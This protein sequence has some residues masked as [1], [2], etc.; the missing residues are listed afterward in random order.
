MITGATGLIG[1]ALVAHFSNQHQLTLVGRTREK[2]QSQFPDRYSIVTW[3]ELKTRGESII[4]DQDVIINLAGENIG[5][6]RWSKK[7]KQK[8]L[9]SRVNATK[10]IASICAHLD[11]SPRILNASAVGIYGFSND[12]TFTENSVL[13]NPECFLETVGD[14]WEKT[15]LIAENANVPVVKM[16]FGVVL[17]NQDGALKK[18]LP[19][20]KWGLG[21]ILGN[22]QQLFSWI[23]LSDLI[24]AID[25]LVLHPEITGPVNMVSPGVVSQKDFA[26]ALARALHRPCFMR[27][28]TWFI[29]FVFGQMGDELLLHGQSVKSEKL[30]RA[31]FSFQFDTVDHALQCLLFK[32]SRALK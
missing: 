13:K 2:I 1:K 4:R 27:L 10:F 15:L 25:F 26:K 21:A 31:G 22:G 16:R 18:M 23:T 17:S 3:D 20:F 6:K 11:K 29:H 5:A 32:G 8:I 12:A 24:R 19:A 7:Q 28:P 30:L 9:D 14:A